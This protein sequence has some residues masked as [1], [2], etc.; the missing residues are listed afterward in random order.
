MGVGEPAAAMCPA[1]IAQLGH[2][3]ADSCITSGGAG[4]GA[5]N[6]WYWQLKDS[7]G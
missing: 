4:E 5:Q 6:W 3:A 1:S 2:R 7:I